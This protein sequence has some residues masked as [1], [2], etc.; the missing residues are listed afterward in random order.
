MS[1]VFWVWTLVAIAMAVA[2]IAQPTALYL[3]WAFGAGAA[4]GLEVLGYGMW[5]Q[6]PVFVVLPSAIIVIHTRLRSGRR[7]VEAETED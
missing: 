5:W 6:W 4:A 1:L 7:R 2:E 3:P